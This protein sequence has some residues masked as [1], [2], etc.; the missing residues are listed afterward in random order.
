MGTGGAGARLKSALEGHE[1]AL[2]ICVEARLP[3]RDN[4]A[5]KKGAQNRQ[6]SAMWWWRYGAAAAVTAGAL[7]LRLLLAPWAGDAVPYLSFSPAVL[8]V[9]WRWGLGPGLLALALGFIAG[10]FFLAAPLGKFGPY[11]GNHGALVLDYIVGAG[12]GVMLLHLLHRARDRTGA[13]LAEKEIEANQRRVA[14]EK[15]KVANVELAKHASELEARVAERTAEWQ[16]TANDLEDLLYSIA[17][18][19]HAPNRAMGGFT[20]I[21][22]GEH[23][24]GLNEEAREL[25]RRIGS[26]A[27]H[28]SALINAVLELGRWSQVQL[29]FKR[30]PLGAI[31]ENVIR[32][33][34][35]KEGV[36]IGL[37]ERWPE[38]VTDSGALRTVLRHLLSN[39][40]KFSGKRAEPRIRVWADEEADGWSLHVEDNGIGIPAGQIPRIFRAM[41][42]LHGP[43]EYPGLGVGLGVVKRIVERMH[44]QIVVTSRLGEG[45]HFE[46]KFPRVE[47]SKATPPPALAPVPR[48]R[49]DEICVG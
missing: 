37:P 45:A 46:V 20:E 43:R 18:N 38:V 33:L 2:P 3:R 17:H 27:R 48:A 29:I 21:L 23:G 42:T 4:V 28:N 26:A 25:L 12:I 39:A 40:V 14:E 5:V 47:P 6:P 10:D 30:V 16:R 1:N 15:L 8:F 34:E 41:E 22:E 32:E 44:G 49:A 7:L 19:L 13:V 11:S 24:Q 31:V 35:L 36:R 9:A